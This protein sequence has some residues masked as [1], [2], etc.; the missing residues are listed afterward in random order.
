MANR[1]PLTVVATLLVL[2]AVLSTGCK[3]KEAPAPA[4][5]RGLKQPS[6]P[7]EVLRVDAKPRELSITAPG[8]VDAFE[9]VQVTARVSGV[10]DKVSFV[11]GQE[12]KRGQILAMIDSRRY[13]LSVS[14][15]RAAVA[16]AEAT[17]ADVQQSLKRRETASENS[18]GLVPGEEIETYRTRLRTAQADT[19]Q[20]GE[21][22]KLA[23]LNLDDSQVKAAAEGT[24]QT[25]NV[26]T[27]QF[28]QAGA[29]IATLLQREPMLLHFNVT[30]A[31]AP[32]L[33]I[34]MPA[35]FTLKESQQAYT[36]K[37]TLV[38]GSADPE[39]RLVPITAE[40][41]TGHKFWLRPG[42]FAAVSVKLTSQRQF[43]MIPQSAAR[44][45]D[46]GFVAFVIQ[47]D[48]AHEKLLELGMHTADGWVEVH[49]GL[50]VGDQ[51]VTRGVEALAEGTK[52]QV[53][54]AT[55]GGSAAAPPASAGASSDTM[56]A[57][58]SGRSGDPEARKRRAGAAASANPNVGG[59]ASAKP[60]AGE[61]P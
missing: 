6:F 12:V 30:T 42:S 13:A 2:F 22:L 35:D 20:A 28:L 9:H 15:A 58:S 19:D 50:D 14:S 33:K 29:V 26:Q 18:P 38:G 27:G 52:V 39:S 41:D 48:T 55:S 57:A 54:P 16:K 59:A 45:S 21:A 11:E 46:R 23:Q 49:S 40:I 31:E 4:G 8:V 34:G 51:I 17:A 53:S 32:R 7:V 1:S 56:P 60:G 24:I 25:R 5:K 47:G 37:I 36:A 44:P 61:A 43:P 3:A 10:V